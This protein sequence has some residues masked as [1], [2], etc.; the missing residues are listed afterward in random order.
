MSRPSAVS[1]LVVD[2]SM[3]PPRCLR[4]ARAEAAKRTGAWIHRATVIIQSHNDSIEQEGNQHRCQTCGSDRP[5]L[6]DAP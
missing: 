3:P 1:G 5:L 4:D 2:A 6:W